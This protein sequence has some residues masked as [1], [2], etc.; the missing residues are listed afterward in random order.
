MGRRHSV[1]RGRRD[2]ILTLLETKSLLRGTV[3]RYRG[4]Q[5]S[6]PTVTRRQGNPEFMAWGSRRFDKAARKK[7]R[8]SCPTSRKFPRLESAAENTFCSGRAR[9]PF[10][11]LGWPGGARRAADGAGR[12]GG[13]SRTR[14]RRAARSGGRR[15]PRTGP[16]DLTGYWFRSTEDYI[17]R[18]FPITCRNATVGR[19]RWRRAGRAAGPQQVAPP[20]PVAFMRRRQHEIPGRLNIT[21]G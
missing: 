21:C 13:P 6:D 12:R 16:G 17:E 2:E 7:L 11:E 8:K 4:T 18:M 10:P 19:R 9:P 1:V 20:I 5:G 14:L 3:A 15:R